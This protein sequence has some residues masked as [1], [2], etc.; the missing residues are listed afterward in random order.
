MVDPGMTSK[1][2]PT[3]KV[4][5]PVAVAM[6]VTANRSPFFVLMILQLSN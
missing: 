5:V 1:A 2:D 3:Q 4:E 6:K